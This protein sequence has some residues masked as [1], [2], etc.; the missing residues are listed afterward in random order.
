MYRID[1]YQK[2][3]IGGLQAFVA[4]GWDFEDVKVLADRKYLDLLPEG[5][6]Y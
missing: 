5:P 2:R 1:G 3:A 6:V 4:N